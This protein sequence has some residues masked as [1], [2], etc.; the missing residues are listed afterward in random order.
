MRPSTAF[1]IGYGLFEYPVM[2]FGLT[3]A[4]ATFQNLTNDTVHEHLNILW[5]IYL[6]NIVVNI[7]NEENH[8]HHVPTIM[9]KL[10]DI[11][12]VSKLEK[13]EFYIVKTEFRGYVISEQV[14]SM[15]SHNTFPG[16]EWNTPASGND[17]QMFL[18]FA[19]V[20]TSSWEAILK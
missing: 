15:N 20:S 16:R 12:M 18:N 19:N 1:Q 2:P 6:T 3:N 7:N 5:V 4:L 8:V 13:C 10:P 11:G 9:N 14:V 17:V